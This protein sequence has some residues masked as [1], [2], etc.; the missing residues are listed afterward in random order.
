MTTS[1][2]TVRLAGRAATPVPGPDEPARTTLARTGEALAA[3]HL[4]HDDGL[5]VIARNWRLSS[6]ELR[7]ELDVVALAESRGLLVVCE[8][9]TR[10][11]ASAYGGPLAAVTPRKQAKV[12]RLTRMFVGQASLRTR[13]IR[14]DVIGVVL[15]S[16]AD[17]VLVHVQDAF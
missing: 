4:G 13:A 2:H 8:V 1:S 17:P 6:G 7:G 9:K 11:S 15:A 5:Q 16:G 3:D 10:R 12:R 14:F